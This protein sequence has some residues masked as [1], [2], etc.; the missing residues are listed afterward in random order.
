MNVDFLWFLVKKN[1][2]LY[3]QWVDIK[4]DWARWSVQLFTDAKQEK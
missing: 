3:I 1:V 2:V 4:G